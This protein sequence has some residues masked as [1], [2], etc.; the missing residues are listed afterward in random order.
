MADLSSAQALHGYVEF[1]SWRQIS[2]TDD[3]AL[4]CHVS[5]TA[6]K[7]ASRSWFAESGVDSDQTGIGGA[8]G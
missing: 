8:E 5:T 1:Q 7:K 3:L 2:R 4:C 6:L